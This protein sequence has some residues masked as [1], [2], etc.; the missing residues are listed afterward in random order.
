MNV[1]LKPFKR[2]K[3]DAVLTVMTGRRNAKNT[4]E[5]PNNILPVESIFKAG[6]KFAYE[7][8]PFSV[9]VIRIKT[10]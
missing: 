9:S 5:E 2:I 4:R 8:P 1:D 10:R 3:S 7:L 6:K